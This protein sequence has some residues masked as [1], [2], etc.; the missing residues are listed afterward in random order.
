MK[1]LFSLTA[2]LL[3]LFVL[4]AQP[5]SMSPGSHRPSMASVRTIGNTTI[6]GWLY[7][8]N[9]S[10]LILTKSLK[11][12]STHLQ[13]SAQEVILVEQ[14]NEFTLQK[15][16]T[17]LKGALIGLGVGVTSGIILGFVSGDDT[18]DWFVF[19]AKAKAAIGGTVLGVTGALTGFIIGALAKKKFI[20]GAK[21]KAYRD[22]RGE[23][24]MRLVQK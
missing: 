8:V 21:K 17:A 14:I 18:G 16:H 24:M 5:D 1:K 10:Q 4:Q 20:I 3:T 19:S 7:A 22:L 6:N 13:G 23:L 12:L 11:T 2:S 9:D 15:K